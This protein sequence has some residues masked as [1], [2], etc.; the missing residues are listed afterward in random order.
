MHSPNWY[1]IPPAAQENEQKAN[2]DSLEAGEEAN[3][4]L[5]TKD[6]TESAVVNGSVSLCGFESGN[7]TNPEESSTA[8]AAVAV[9]DDDDE[10]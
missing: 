6:S 2:A 7:G 4:V 10:M 3:D 8:P 1:E 5:L 9:E